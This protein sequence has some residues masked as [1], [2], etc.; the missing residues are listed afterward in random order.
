MLGAALQAGKGSNPFGQ[1]LASNG[2]L[3]VDERE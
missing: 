1:R 3:R 2:S